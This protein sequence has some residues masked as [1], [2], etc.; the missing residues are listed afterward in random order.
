MLRRL[1]MVECEYPSLLLHPSQYLSP[2]VISHSSVLLSPP[3][4]TVFVF[5]EGLR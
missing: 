3:I 5:L 4:L 2:L 1:D